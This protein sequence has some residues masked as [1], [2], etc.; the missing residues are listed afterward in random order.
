MGVGGSTV[1]VLSIRENLSSLVQEDNRPIKDCL[2]Y[3]VASSFL[4]HGA[5]VG[6]AVFG[7]VHCAACD[8]TVHCSA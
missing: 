5:L 7:C 1:S 4:R 6:D 3:C 8:P 2:Q